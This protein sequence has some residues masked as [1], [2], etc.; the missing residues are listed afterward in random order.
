[1]SLITYLTRIHFAD[2]V[3]EDALPEE[4][5]LLGFQRVMLLT[6]AFGAVAD[7][8]ER[9]ECAMPIEAS[10]V[11]VSAGVSLADAAAIWA[12]EGCDGVIALGGRLA[13]D[14][15]L[16]VAAQAR[17]A[18]TSRY[19]PVIA[20]PT[21]TA[22]LGLPAAPVPAPGSA[23]SKCP[24]LPS[25]VLCDPT[26]TLW[27]DA[28]ITAAAGMDVIVHC[29]ETYLST[30][31]NPPADGMA[32]DGLRRVATWLERAVAYKGDILARRELLAAA[33]NAALAGQ[34]GLGAVHALA[35]AVEANLSDDT[36]H[37]RFH[38][39]LLPGV[40]RFN[41]PAGAERCGALAEAL[42][43]P[44]DAD[45]ADW[46]HRFGTGLGLPASLAGLGFDPVACGRIAARAAEDLANRTNPRH[47]TVPDFCNLLAEAAA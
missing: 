32:L 24:P 26:L 36:P 40:L 22:G 38:A 3:L 4:M 9:V 34:K 44:A 46:L 11:P 23:R 37:G 45:L 6:D 42:R 18:R 39:A 31:W 10:V 7:L 16:E 43:L 1:M 2:R 41:A 8:A 25:V 30:T 29:I 33:L 12:D 14:K 15:G 28:D 19:L 5:R 20:V 13:L 47:A 27:A 35:S 21:T 17:G